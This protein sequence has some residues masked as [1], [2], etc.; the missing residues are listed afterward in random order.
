MERILVLTDFSDIA[1]RG[2]EA[3][4]RLARHLGGAEIFL[5]NT[6]RPPQGREFSVTG[7]IYYTDNPEENHF[8]M[9]LLRKNKERLEQAAARYEGEGIHITPF[10]EVGEMQ[11]IVDDFIDKR[12]VDLIVMGTSGENTF[13]EYF[14]GNHTEQVIRVSHVPVIS[15]KVTDRPMEIRTIV[16]ATDLNDKA[17]TGMRYI[18]ALSDKLGAH[19]HLVHVTKSGKLQQKRAD[20]EKYVLDHGITNYTIGAIED[21]DTE[22][23]IKRYAAQVGADMIAI[24]TRGRDGLA[25]LLSHSVA[26]DVIREASVPV[27]TINMSELKD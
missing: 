16:L 23:G 11:D 9:A 20:M 13:E 2:L 25:A 10:M 12:Q 24:I 17:A 19:L 8:M 15:V 4:V 1:E 3:A 18:N 26:L 21:S 27:L 5:L 7:D 14:V 22:D 6:E